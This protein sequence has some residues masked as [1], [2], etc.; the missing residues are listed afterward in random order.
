MESTY[1]SADAKSQRK[2]SINYSNY[3]HMLVLPFYKTIWNS[4]VI[5]D[6][7]FYS[8][9]SVS[10]QIMSPGMWTGKCSLLDSSTGKA[11]YWLPKPSSA[12][13]AATR[14]PACRPHTPPGCTA[15]SAMGGFLQ[16]ILNILLT[17]SSAIPWSERKCHQRDFLLAYFSA[18]ML[19]CYATSVWKLFVKG[20]TS[21]GN[22]KGQ[23]PRGRCK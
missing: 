11:F 15:D 8:F 20:Q 2:H 10:S 6:Q 12:S 19:G 21:T 13:L 1:Y 18:K 3:W 14:V 23:E 5:K 9:V 16:S 7:V 22:N 17:T 4:S